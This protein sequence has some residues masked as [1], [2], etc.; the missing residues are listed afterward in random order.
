MHWPVTSSSMPSTSASRTGVTVGPFQETS[1]SG[2]LN[3]CFCLD[4]PFDA[5]S[6][7]QGGQEYL[8]AATVAFSLYSALD[9]SV[10]PP[11]A[12]VLMTGMED[13]RS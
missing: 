10:R 5:T 12:F 2:G 4:I 7:V 1:L 6:E 3:Y 9:R 13:E 11:E 8:Q